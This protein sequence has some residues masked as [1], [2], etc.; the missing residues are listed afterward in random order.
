MWSLTYMIITKVTPSPV[1][2]EKMMREGQQSS[3]LTTLVEIG[4]YTAA[5]PVT[6][7]LSPAL[8][9]MAVAKSPA[10]SVPQFPHIMPR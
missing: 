4:S 2:D 1:A 5:A 6:I 3:W 9:L 10:P 7:I 8:P